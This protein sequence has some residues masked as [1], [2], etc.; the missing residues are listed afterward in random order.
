MR[1]KQYLERE[2]ETPWNV[3]AGYL[4]P[5]HDSYV[6]EKLG[7]RDWIPAKDRCRLCEAAIQDGMGW[8]GLGWFGLGCVELGWVEMCWIWM[9]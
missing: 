3:L 1:V 4:S 9:G 2:L 8:D 6:H 7:D 5:T